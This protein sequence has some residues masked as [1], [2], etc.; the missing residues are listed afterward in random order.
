M[1]MEKKNTMYQENDT[2]GKATR[3]ATLIDKGGVS[4][5]KSGNAGNVA[6]V[7]NKPREKFA[8]QK[9]HNVK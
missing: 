8:V 7:R 3:K 2:R 1:T 6:I 4:V 5:Q 9:R